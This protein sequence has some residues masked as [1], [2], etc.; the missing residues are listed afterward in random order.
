MTKFVKIFLIVAILLAIPFSVVSADAKYGSGLY[1]RCNYGSC[2]IIT[3]TSSGSVNIDVTPTGSGRCTIANDSVSVLTHNSAG[4]T[5]SATNSSTN[6]NLVDG[7]NTIASSSGTTASP[8]TL[9]N[10]WGFRV[11][12][13]SAMGSGP[14]TAV[15]SAVPGA[16]TFAGFPASSSTAAT[17]ATTAVYSASAVVTPVWIGVCADTTVASGAYTSAVTYTAVTN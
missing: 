13:L 10:S 6:T 7:S 16:L 3:L 8:A 9:S 11:D 17:L 4:F 5:L 15:S 14:T 2:D 1:G 12:G